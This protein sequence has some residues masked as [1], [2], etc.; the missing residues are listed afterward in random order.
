MKKIL[1]SY[2]V[3][4]LIGFLIFTKYSKVYGNHSEDLKQFT[5][6]CPPEKITAFYSKMKGFD[7]FGRIQYLVMF[8]PHLTKTDGNV[9]LASLKCVDNIF[10]KYHGEGGLF[11]LENAKV[12]WDVIYKNNVIYWKLPSGKGLY[13]IP[14]VDSK[15]EKLFAWKLL[16]Y[17]RS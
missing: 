10:Q 16:L 9:Y 8:E 15:T 5:F 2:I 3:F 1:I 7:K 14:Q 11:L 12:K 6:I 17:K 13:V 4:I